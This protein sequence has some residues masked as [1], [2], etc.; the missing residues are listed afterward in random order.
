MQRKK[1]KREMS[2]HDWIFSI[3]PEGSRINGAWKLPHILTLIGCIAAIVIITF[4]F[5]KREEKTR[6]AVIRVLI[7]LILF[8]EIARRVINFIKGGQETWNDY[9]YTLL[10][11]PWCAISCWALII[12]MFANKKFLWNFA[13]LSAFLCAL[14]FFAYPE[15]G[16][17]N[18]YIMFENLYSIGTHALLLVTSLSLI[19]LKFTQFDYKTAWKEGVCLAV[20]YVYAFIEIY[21]LDIATDPLYFMPDNDVAKVLG[22]MS[23]AVYLPLYIV[24]LCVYFGAFYLVQYLAERKKRKTA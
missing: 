16:F 7:G 24:F 13:S 18:K 2:F 8:F 1:E 14:I 10:P 9:L 12:A 15:A 19:T 11:R 3:A 22:G 5:R 21:L 17:T 23:Y 20:V 4:A 6:T